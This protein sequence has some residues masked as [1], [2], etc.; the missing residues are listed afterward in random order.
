MS[1][2]KNDLCLLG[3]GLKYSQ[4]NNYLCLLSEGL[5]YL[6]A[7]NELNPLGE[8]PPHNSIINPCQKTR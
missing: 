6:K 1:Q 7:N 5:M 8:G 2:A 4:V 3:E